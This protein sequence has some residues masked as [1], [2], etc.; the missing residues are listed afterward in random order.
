MKY[1]KQLNLLCLLMI[2]V[3]FK[4]LSQTSFSAKEF[5][6]DHILIFSEMED[7]EYSKQQGE[8]NYGEKLT[9]VHKNQGTEGHYYIFYNTF[10]EFLSLK[11]PIIAK[12]NEAR[13]KS[14]YS[15]RWDKSS[16]T[17][18]FGFG[19]SLTPFDTNATSFPLQSY[20]SLDSPK[21]EYYLMS[22]FNADNSQP[23]IYVSSPQRSYTKIDSLPELD[24]LFKAPV[25][26]DF[27]SYLSHPNGVKRLTKVIITL[28]KNIIGRNIDLL[29]QLPDIE[30]VQGNH[31]AL[32][33]V[34]DD[35]K[36]GKEISIARSFDLRLQY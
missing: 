26:K 8:L 5:Q 3:T 31:Y 18:P 11:D 12:E 9:T 4:S 33:L 6:L 32:T 16:Q 35:A 30:V 20:H 29:Q 10:I 19:L 1:K 2:L 28:P 17:C 13:F 15:S 7:L 34:F 21:D 25:L 27:K 14:N 23:L 22:S 24:Q 36:Q